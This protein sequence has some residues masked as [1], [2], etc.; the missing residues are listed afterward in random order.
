MAKFLDARLD[1]TVDLI[2]LQLRLQYRRACRAIAERK[3]GHALGRAHGK[4]PAPGR[5]QGTHAQN[6]G[7]AEGRTHQVR[8]VHGR[9]ERSKIHE[10]LSDTQRHCSQREERWRK[11]H[12]NMR[13]KAGG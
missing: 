4:L 1:N 7:P 9:K 8:P 2:Y 10:Q 5:S 3:A 11:T 6:E 12:L 13:L